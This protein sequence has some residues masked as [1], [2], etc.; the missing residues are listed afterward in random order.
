MAGQ[1]LRIAVVAPSSPFDNERLQAGV[2]TLQAWG[3]SVELGA[4]L[5]DRHL[6][7]AGTARDRLADLCDALTRPDAD[8]VWM[9]RGGA[10]LVHLLA[11]LPVELPKDRPLFGFSDG[12]A[13]HCALLRRGHTQLWHAPVVQQLADWEQ[14]AAQQAVLLDPPSRQWLRAMLDRGLSTKDWSQHVQPWTHPL[15]PDAV[16]VQGPVVTGN[17][18]VL[19]SLCGTPWQLVA[20]DAIVVLEDLHEAPYRIDRCLRQ[21]TAAGAFAGIR[22][23]VLGDFLHCT[24]QDYALDDVLAEAL[25][26]LQVPV[27]KGIEVGHGSRNLAVRQGATAQIRGTQLTWLD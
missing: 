14:F 26:P 4:H 15:L 2:R 23:V 24:A 3:H 22:A 21:L 18:T 1:S 25:A 12:T 19:A 9:A 20:Q 13:L 8:A 7:F 6:H 16:A 10:G 27:W 17:L 5:H 11:E